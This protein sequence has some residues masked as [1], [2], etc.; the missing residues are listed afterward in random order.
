LKYIIIFLF[1]TSPVFAAGTSNYLLYPTDSTNYVPDAAGWTTAHPSIGTEFSAP[2]SYGSTAKRRADHTQLTGAYASF[3]PTN[4]LIVYSRYTP[5]NTDGKFVLVHAENSTSAW[6]MFTATNTVATILRFKPSLGASSNN[7]GEVNELRWD[8]TGQHPYRLY[9]VGRAIQQT[10]NLSGENVA[11]SFYYVDIDPDTGVQST[12]VLI[13]DFANEFP[14]A[15]TYP[16]GGYANATIMNDVEGDSSVD[17]RYWAFQVMNTTISPNAPYAIITYDKQTNTI[18][19]RLQRDCTGV[20]GA[21]TVLDT[22]MSKLPYLTRPN[23][24]EISP[25]GTKI[26][27]NWGNS[28]DQPSTLSGTWTNIAGAIWEFT[29]YK[30]YT[31]GNSG[32]SDVTVNG[33][34][35]AATVQGL[36]YP[37][38]SLPY[39]GTAHSNI[40]GPGQYAVDGNTKFWIRLPDDSDPNGKTIS[41]NWGSRPYNL[42]TIS[43]GPQ[44]CNKDMSGC[45]R[46]ACDETH[47]GWAWGANGE[48]ILVTQN[49]KTD[50][51]DAVDITSST[52]AAC[53]E[54]SAFKYKC[55]IQIAS[56][57]PGFD[58]TYGTGVHFSKMYNPNIKGWV[59]LGTAAATMGNWIKNQFVMMEIK[60]YNTTPAPRE[61]RISPSWN[62]HGDYR[63]EGSGAL[64]FNATEIWT[65][66]NFGTPISSHLN[67]VYSIGLPDNWHITLDPLADMTAPVTSPNKSGRF[68]SSQLVTLTANETATT[69][70]CRSNST[71][72]TPATSYTSP[73]KVLVNRSYE[74]LCYKSTDSASNA[75]ATKCTE[76]RKQR[77]G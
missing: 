35:M 43:N 20:S 70:Y 38:Y 69:V 4:S 26:H 62:I 68:Q 3:A 6:V 77:R 33:V 74:K 60:P 71:D 19:G 59:L 16:T 25:A 36:T 13:R 10:Q 30:T 72:C 11:T 32:F 8:Y 75:E 37:D 31:N 61:W 55:G 14:A 64:N 40:T 45:F 9:F 73:V 29:G 5:V 51:I 15:G 17:S 28:S 21:C 57:Y 2:D 54:V 1:T 12:P 67:E 76:F 42:G 56:L 48:E 34:S 50:Y 18:L 22:P 46:V 58:P 52:T 24:V 41:A 53:S 49:S 44:A 39:K 27:I 23:M 47:S 63:S 7:L 65:T 66:G